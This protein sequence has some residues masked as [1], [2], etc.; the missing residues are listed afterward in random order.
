MKKII[1][2][3]KIFICIILFSYSFLTYTTLITQK[4]SPRLNLYFNTIGYGK[5]ISESMLPTLEIGDTITLV[6]EDIAGLEVGEI[7]L[8]YSEELE[9]NIIH[10]LIDIQETDEGTLYIFKGDN[11]NINDEPVRKENIIGKAVQI[12]KG[13]SFDYIILSSTISFFIGAGFILS[14]FKPKDN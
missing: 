11:N 12:K 9:I 1:N 10:R 6:N 8:Y 7:Y 13:F 3:L 2:I 5:V 4:F 14:F